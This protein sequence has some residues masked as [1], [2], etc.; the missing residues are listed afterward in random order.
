M[1]SCSNHTIGDNAVMLESAQSERVGGTPGRVLQDKWGGALGGGFQLIPNVL[2]RAQKQLGLDSVDLVVLLNLNLHWWTPAELPHPRP[3]VIANRMGLSKRTVERSLQRLAK[4]GYVERL[5][6]LRKKDGAIV[7][8][9]RL[10]GL[11]ERLRRAV[12]KG[13]AQQAYRAENGPGEL[14][15]SG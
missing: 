6:P 8:P 14:S 15:D 1:V 12:E 3:T 10:T 4:L 5:P 11:V 13:R 2:I 7:R 9:Y